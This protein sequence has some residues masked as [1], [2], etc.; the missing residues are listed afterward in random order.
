M[1]TQIRKLTMAF[2]VAVGVLAIAGPGAQAGTLAPPPLL[3]QA[4][5][6]ALKISLTLPPI[7]QLKSALA[8]A[9]LPVNAVPDTGL[10][11]LTIE[12]TVSTTHGDVWS[13]NQNLPA[14]NSRT[15]SG[16]GKVLS[17][18]VSG[19]IDNQKDLTA[20]SS[21]CTAR[22][23]NDNKFTCT[24]TK[25]APA[26]IPSKIELPLGI[27]V[28]EVA[29]ASSVTN[30]VSATDNKIGLVHV[31]LD[32]SPLLGPG[33]TLATVG[34]AI[35]TA[36]AAVN[37]NV[38]GAINGVID[39]VRP[40]LPHVDNV[41]VGHMSPIPSITS[42]ALLDMTVMPSGATISQ[43]GGSSSGVLQSLAQSKVADIRLFDADGSD[44]WVSI[45]SVVAR[46]DASALGTLAQLGGSVSKTVAGKGMKEA[47]NETNALAGKYTAPGKASHSLQI[48]DMRVGGQAIKVTD[49]GLDAL[50][51]GVAPVLND[52]GTRLGLPAQFANVVTGAR[53][54]DQMTGL[55]IQRV[56]GNAMT[57]KGKLISSAASTRSGKAETA[58][59]A[60]N[61]AYDAVAD[62]GRITLMLQ[63]K[64]PKLAAL[65]AAPAGTVPDLKAG[66]F[67][68][69]GIAL[70]VDLPNAHSFVTQGARVEALRFARTGVAGPMWMGACMLFGIA[71]L[72]RKFALAK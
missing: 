47:K 28:I 62:S 11:G 16:F 7:D 57:H 55:S 42:A 65:Q 45:G 18:S 49:G 68:A 17:V 9:G 31:H 4:D 3:A 30:S 46:A 19:I 12:A 43:V 54:L 39:T 2:A 38:V 27:G 20:V 6:E 58:S 50:R 67:V 64:L 13:A 61:L 48:N 40:S 70:K 36:V 41:T 24:S 8:T 60:G 56:A 15:A 37:K 35:D 1:R 10:K 21:K 59:A 53:L 72:V 44:P 25:V 14:G 26:D 71:L 69:T 5:A 22:K 34:S 52:L 63:P 51:N 33:Q 32:L 66:D 23:V 29:P